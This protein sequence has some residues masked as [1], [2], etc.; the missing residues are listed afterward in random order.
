MAER[1][2]PGFDQ[3]LARK[4]RLGARRLFS[5]QS[6]EQPVIPQQLLPIQQE[7]QVPKSRSFSLRAGVEVFG[8]NEGVRAQATVEFGAAKQTVETEEETLKKIE[9]A[10]NLDSSVR[11]ALIKGIDS[12]HPNFRLAV[13]LVERDPNIDP[14]TARQMMNIQE[15]DRKVAL[16]ETETEA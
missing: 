1:K 8:D 14:D 15:N 9:A 11:G 5:G 13:F 10:L 4:L 12:N 6:S 2:E 16:P 7:V 3:K